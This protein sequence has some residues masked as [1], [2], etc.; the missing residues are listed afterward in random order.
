[1]ENE[2]K[3]IN[4][5]YFIIKDTIKTYIGECTIEQI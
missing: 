4:Q 1:M 5:N 3:S 2:N